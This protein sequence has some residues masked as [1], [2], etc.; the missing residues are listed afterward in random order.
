MR[1][2][3]AALL[4][5]FKRGVLVFLVMLAL[6]ISAYNYCQ[7]LATVTLKFSTNF[8]ANIAIYA[9]ICLL[10]I[11]LCGLLPRLIQRLL[12]RCVDGFGKEANWHKTDGSI[13]ARIVTGERMVD[14]I[15]CHITYDAS[16][17]G[18]FLMKA[19]FIPKS[20]RLK[21]TGRNTMQVLFSASLW[22]LGDADK[23]EK[24]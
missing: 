7:T 11:C 20:G 14:G 16:F 21:L 15:A 17:F 6:A 13:E 10:L 24:N 23:Q 12:H 8:W 3:F 2:I 18:L 22:W 4:G 5:S 9:A 19:T 1:K